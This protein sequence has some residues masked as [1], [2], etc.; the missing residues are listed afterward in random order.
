MNR[1]YV[2]LWRKSIES[3]WLSNH[4]LWAFW[5]WCLMKASHKEYDLV[6]G[7]QTV[8]LLPGDLIF[9]RKAASIELRMSEQ[10]IRTAVDSMRKRKNLTIK[11][12]N[13]FSIISIINWETYQDQETIDN[14]QSNQPLTNNQ[15]TTNHKQECK[16]L[17]NKRNI[18]TD[19]F[20]AFYSAYP[21][22]LAKE[23]AWKAWKKITPELFPGLSFI[24]S[25]IEKFKKT[26]DWKKE[27]GKYIPHPATWINQKRWTDELKSEDKSS[28]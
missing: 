3:G 19:D 20:L 8:H 17:K 11:S 10:E 18:Y 22:H 25:K 14:Q 23:E 16:E 9:G 15:P 13:K 6:V 26:D 27:D 1:G 12:T 4:K 21:K 24:L 28:W 7:C 2:K 5:C